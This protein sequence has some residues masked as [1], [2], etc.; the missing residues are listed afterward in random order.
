MHAVT[1][2]VQQKQVCLVLSQPE[3]AE[4]SAGSEADAPEPSPGW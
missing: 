2:E 1:T 4:E 3:A